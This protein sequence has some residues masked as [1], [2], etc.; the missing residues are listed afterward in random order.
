[1]MNWLVIWLSDPDFEDG[2]THYVKPGH[3][4]TVCGLE[5]Q[6]EG[7]RVADTELPLCQECLTLSSLMGY[8]HPLVG[9]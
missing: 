6:E 3:P 1:M 9:A 5:M 7:R 4:T 8:R 2:T